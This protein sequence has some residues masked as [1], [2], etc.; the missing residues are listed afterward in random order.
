MAT[1]GRPTPVV[2][3]HSA[4][5]TPQMWQSQ[6]EAIG[7]ERQVMAPWVAGLRPG[8]QGD[9]SLTGAAAQL[10]DSLD[11]HG[12]EKAVLV[13][14]Q[15]GAMVALHVA[16]T[17]PERVA[18]LV[19]SGAMVTPGRM[20]LALQKSLIRMLPNRTLADSGA[21]KAD[22]IKALDVIAG[23]DLGAGLG[24]VQTEVLVI[25]GAGDPLLGAARQ[26]ADRLPNAHLV[27]LPNAG[28]QPNLEQPAAYN[29]ALMDFLRR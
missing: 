10:V 21:T 2:L 6:V 22:L 12:I 25:A 5:L 14:H 23:A 3:L 28:A 11:V 9:L 24:R 15:L 17:E 13:G 29:A 1:A 4:G 16:A 19:V 27:E 20:A 18:G 8:R 7:A 26:L